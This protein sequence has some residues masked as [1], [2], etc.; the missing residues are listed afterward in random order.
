MS[1][2]Q[3]YALGS[4]F[5]PGR[6]DMASHT[7]HAHH[8]GM[9]VIETG[10]G[11]AI[12]M[13][14]YRAELIGDPVRKVVFG[15]AITTLLDHASGLAVAC[16]LDVLRAIA[17]VDLRVDYLR[18]AAPGLDLYARVDCYKVTRNVA[19]I[20]GI[21]YERGPDDPFASCL[22]TFMLGA[23]PAGSSFERF[24]RDGAPEDREEP[25]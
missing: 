18:A 11:F 13:L 9:K 24:M 12:I 1:S 3:Q 22:G 10:P 17:T 5:G 2:N 14:P 16:A 23:N 25:S 20:R 6:D 4:L 15:G 21:A 7:P 19:F 8:L